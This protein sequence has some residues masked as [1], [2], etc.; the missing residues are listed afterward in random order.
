MSSCTTRSTTA[1][2]KSKSLKKASVPTKTQGAGQA[3][4]TSTSPHVKT[5]A[6]ILS[7]HKITSDSHCA[8]IKCKAVS[9]LLKAFPKRPCIKAINTL[10]PFC[11]NPAIDDLRQYLCNGPKWMEG[12]K[13]DYLL[14][15]RAVKPSFVCHFF[16]FIS[17]LTCLYLSRKTIINSCCNMTG[18]SGASD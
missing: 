5:S 11:S 1:P 4:T 12:S 2:A 6:D 16:S 3:P 9:E 17:F 15:L 10:H 14:A 18:M 13:K 8:T 7:K